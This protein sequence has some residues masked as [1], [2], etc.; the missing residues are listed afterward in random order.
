MK[1]LLLILLSTLALP[2]HAQPT[3]FCK[4]ALWYKK[5][6][7]EESLTISC[8]TAYLLNRY[9][10][11]YYQKLYKS[12]RSQDQRVKA[13]TTAYADIT[14]LYE[15]RIAQQNEEYNR[16]RKSF[17]ELSEGSQQLLQKADE[18]L[19]SIQTLLATADKNIHNTQLNLTQV[20]QNLENEIRQSNKARIRSVATGF[21]AGAVVTALIFVAAE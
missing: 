15:N 17:D 18:R 16:L 1:K 12:Y 11:Q 20:E 19:T 10:F 4:E 3:E 14:T 6:K 21:A 8:D 13:L 2:A 7:R 9:T 5:Y